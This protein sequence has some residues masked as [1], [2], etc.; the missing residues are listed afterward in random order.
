MSILIQINRSVLME[1]FVNT[2]IRSANANIVL[3]METKILKRLMLVAFS[4]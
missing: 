1:T 2:W 4:G 3:V